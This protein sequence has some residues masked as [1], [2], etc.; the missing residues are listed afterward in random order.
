M[1]PDSKFVFHLW[2]PDVAMQFM[3]KN[4][5]VCVDTEVH[6]LNVFLKAKYGQLGS[7]EEGLKVLVKWRNMVRI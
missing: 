7:V 4:I 2:F 6:V 1:E 3:T 5:Y